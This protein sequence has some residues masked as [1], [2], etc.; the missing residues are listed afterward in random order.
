MKTEK[1]EQKWNVLS[2]E[3]ISGL[4]EW[5]LQ[6][7]KANFRE[8]E[9]EVDERLSVLRAKMLSDT[10]I[11]S[12]QTEL[13][14][15]DA[16]YLCPSCGGELERK[17]KK[18]RKLQTRGGQEV[19]LEREYGV[20]KKCGHGF[21][22]L[23]EELALLP[24]ALT[25]HGHEILVRLSSWMPFAKATQI[26]ADVMGIH[27]SKSLGQ[28]YTEASGLAYE[29]IQKEAVEEIERELPAV[30]ADAERIQISA[31]GAMVP[32]LH[33]IWAEVRTLVIGEIPPVGERG[34]EERGHA[35]NLSYFSRK[36]SAEEF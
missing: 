6:H 13:A 4:A 21:F 9:S 16:L 29:E 20:C 31:D 33:G 23:D 36:V 32:L 12:S 7:P 14:D 3:I 34:N 2:A 5:R 28:R 30:K 26:L 18:K 22:P 10:A 1:M 11:L 8:I 35:R 27:V 17:G 24:G 19:E 25:P 15:E